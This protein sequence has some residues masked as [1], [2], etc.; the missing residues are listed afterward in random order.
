MKVNGNIDKLKVSISTQAT[1]AETTVN[2]TVQDVTDPIAKNN[3]DKILI[4][5]V[6]DIQGDITLTITN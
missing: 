6:K 4:I 5:N 2:S 3:Y 1:G